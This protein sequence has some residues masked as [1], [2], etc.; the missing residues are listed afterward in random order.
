MS[1]RLK[2][3]R[4]IFLLHRTCHAVRIR[5]SGVIQCSLESVF[6]TDFLGPPKTQPS[7][8]TAIIFSKVRPEG[9]N[10]LPGEAECLQIV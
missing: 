9:L 1:G 6:F 7:A 3:S 5:Q 10:L 8:E 2:L 4:V